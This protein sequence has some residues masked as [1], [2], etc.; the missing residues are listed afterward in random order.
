MPVAI[1]GAV[2]SGKSTLLNALLGEDRAI[3]SDTPGTTRDTVEE[4]MVLGGVQFRFIDTAGIRDASDSVEK[5]GIERS[6]KSLAQ[7]EVVLGVVDGCS[8]AED[9]RKAALEISGRISP[10][11]TLIMLFNK[12]DLVHEVHEGFPVCDLKISAK[13]GEGL[14][15]LR[16]RIVSAYSLPSTGGDAT[17]VTNIRHYEALARAREDLSRVRSGL[18]LGTPS[19]LLAEDLRSAIRELGSIFGEIA[20]DEVLNSIFANFCIGK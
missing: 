15:E 11:Q 10:A 1:V 17:L 19:D 9:A 2:N 18:D 14:D 3:V 6:L 12:T 5:I 8:S 16:K 4:V 20:P 13:T 7:A